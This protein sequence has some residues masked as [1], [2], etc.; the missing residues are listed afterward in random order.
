MTR[1]TEPP[2]FV[3]ACEQATGLAAKYRG[4]QWIHRCP[5]HDDGNPSAATK[6]TETGKQL[7]TCYA[8]CRTEDMCAA[9]G[10]TVADLEPPEHG[11]WTPAGPAV[12]EYPYVDE[13]GRE[14]F[15]VHRAAGKQFRQS[16]PAQHPGEGGRSGRVWNLRGVR[17]ILYRLP[18]V[19][20]AVQAGQRVYIVEGEKDV[21]AVE[22]AGGVATCSPQ[23]AGKWRQ[24][25]PAAI[26]HLRGADVTIVADRDGPGY[27]HARD[28]RAS[29]Q[30]IAASVEVRVAASGK[31]AA[32]HLAGGLLDLDDLDPY[33]LDT[34]STTADVQPADGPPA[35]GDDDAPDAPQL[36]AAPPPVAMNGYGANGHGPT[37]GYR[38]T[39]SM[40][41]PDAAWQSR[42]VLQRIRHAALARLT[43]PEALLGN[44]LARVAATS[45]HTIRIP[46]FVG[47]T[48]GLSIIVGIV[49][50]P[51]V[52][53]S[54]SNAVARDLLPVDVERAP[55]SG[56][57]LVE[58]LFDEVTEYVE[59][60]IVGEDG[61]HKRHADGRVRTR[62]TKVTRKVQGRHN[63]FLYVDEGLVLT[64]LGGRSGS[65][66][67]PTLRSIYSSGP[68]GQTNATD[69]RNR[70]VDPD[71]YV[72]GVVVGLQPEMAD[73][74]MS[75]EQRQAGTPQRFLWLPASLPAGFEL[76]DR[77]DYPHGIAWECPEPWGGVQGDGHE[78]LDYDDAIADEVLAAHLDKLHGNV[79]QLD[80]HRMLTR[81]K[82]AACLSL[83]DG[84][85]RIDLDDWQLADDVM[86]VSDATREQM[87]AAL[88]AS[89]AA[90]RIKAVERRVADEGYAE[91]KLV[92]EVVAIIAERVEAGGTPRREVAR[93]LS[94]RQREVF[95]LAVS[96][97]VAD[98]AVREVDE[99][100][101]GGRG[102]HPKRMLYPG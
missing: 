58:A 34:P 41:L 92:D 98:G 60:P 3:R 67:L 100:P 39:T 45:R 42:P 81:V 52:G 54:A 96:R 44:V 30:G 7:V 62:T 18:R 78:V 50:P 12:A 87:I 13:H 94:K 37:G 15:T 75:V 4:G 20:D 73:G 6:V 51:G 2:P 43:S 36:A 80:G 56:E 76:A 22:A 16:R 25:D 69:E 84:R 57:G 93:A 99:R 88:A 24:L 95:E 71:G 65:T 91:R 86:R 47:G 79:D 101:S 32:D 72:Y 48:Q 49:G 9:V 17:R 46:A 64:A 14:L 8:G 33:D 11:S 10:M 102:G 55:G 5:H 85:L 27:A 29:L 66:L 82:V 61:E 83:L 77:P 19:I 40:R 26:E 68:L 90:Q 28:V 35:P 31:D 70:Q 74:I 63:A 59:S 21:H 23:G 38:E 89:S 97:G 53:K 1:P